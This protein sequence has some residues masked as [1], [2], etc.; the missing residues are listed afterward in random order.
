MENTLYRSLINGMR[1]M[2]L[3]NHIV[4]EPII[5]KGQ[6]GIILMELLELAVMDGDSTFLGC[7]H[8]RFNGCPIYCEHELPVQPKL[9]TYHGYIS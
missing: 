4:N 8:L 9:N 6:E 7:G 2:L 3:S 1:R 5:L